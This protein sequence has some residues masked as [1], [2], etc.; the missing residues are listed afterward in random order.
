MRRVASASQ[1]TKSLD[2]TRKYISLRFLL[3]VKNS[4]MGISTCRQRR[5]LHSSAL[6]QLAERWHLQLTVSNRS[7]FASPNATTALP[8]P[9]T[10][11]LSWQYPLPLSHT[12]ARHWRGAATVLHHLVRRRLQ[13]IG[14]PNAI[15][16]DAGNK[17]IIAATDEGALA[18]VG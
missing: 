17:R 15:E 3:I 6:V 9:C 5:V 7:P 10:D 2:N 4:W 8:Q 1:C 11:L 16:Y 12:I 18:A 14:K 13:F